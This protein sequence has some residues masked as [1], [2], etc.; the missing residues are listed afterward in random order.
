[1]YIIIIII[2]KKENEMEPKIGDKKEIEVK[3]KRIN[4]V[5]KE[6]FLKQLKILK[7]T[8]I[9]TEELHLIFYNIAKRYSSINSFRNYSFREDMIQEAYINC[10]KVAHKF[11]IENRDN[12]FAYFTT[13]IHRNFL[14]Y[15]NKEKIQQEKKWIALRDTLAKY[16][17]EN[18]IDLPLPK[19]IME[20]V[21]QY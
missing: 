11:D 9:L 6:Y 1:M 19:E 8:K 12:P 7:K 16:K 4:Y 13:V 17:I 3:V 20:K 14:N 2:I 18:Q 15:L 21:N 5:E 10:V